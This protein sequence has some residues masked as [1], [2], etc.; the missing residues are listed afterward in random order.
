MYFLCKS[1]QL[2]AKFRYYEKGFIYTNTTELGH[3]III[4]DQFRVVGPLNKIIIYNNN[5]AHLADI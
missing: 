2:R 3:G 5:V 1:C 4:D